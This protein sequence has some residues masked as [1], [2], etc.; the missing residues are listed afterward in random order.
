[1]PVSTI[2]LKPPI[3]K[4]LLTNA[5]FAIIRSRTSGIWRAT[6]ANFTTKIAISLKYSA[7]S[8]FEA[9]IVKMARWKKLSIVISEFYCE[10]DE[11]Y[12]SLSRSER[13][14]RMKKIIIRDKNSG[15]ICGICKRP[16]ARIYEHIEE[17]HLKIAAYRCQFCSE[18]FNS[19]RKLGE[20]IRKF[21]SEAY[22]VERILH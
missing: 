16:F 19:N 4:L 13:L 5:A 8:N 1:M 21:H 11:E 2:T 22:N 3:W 12:E 20:H 18:A 15:T 14:Q 9:K 6:F 17:K 10:Y 7:N